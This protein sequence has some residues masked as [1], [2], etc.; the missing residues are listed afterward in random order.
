[1]YGLYSVWRYTFTPISLPISEDI[2]AAY[3]RFRILTKDVNAVINMNN[4]VIC[5]CIFESDCLFRKG[6]INIY[7]G[8]LIRLLI[9]KIEVKKGRKAARD[10][11][12]RIPL[13]RVDNIKKIT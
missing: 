4:K 9:S 13:K 5:N 12:S 2:L 7:R 1:M 6:S 10:N 3:Q 8:C 11:A